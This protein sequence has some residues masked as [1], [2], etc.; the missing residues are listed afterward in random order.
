MAVGVVG[1]AGGAR[2]VLVRRWPCSAR[3]VGMARRELQREMELSGLSQLAAEAAE[4]VLSELLTN[5]VRH[6]RNPR[7]RQMGVRWERTGTGVRLEVHDADVS[8]PV[9]REVDADA[10]AGRGLALV[11]ALTQG[12][13]GV[14]EREHR[15]GKLV[16]AVISNDGAEG[17]PAANGA[18]HHGKGA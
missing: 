6:A 13:W 9:Q 11:D 2:P 7:G 3:S 16:W 5:V 10:E 18:G 17:K 8:L 4:L 12:R 1:Q 14:E 15:I